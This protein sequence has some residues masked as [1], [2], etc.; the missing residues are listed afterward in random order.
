MTKRLTPEMMMEGK[1]EWWTGDFPCQSILWMVDLAMTDSI[2]KGMVNYSDEGFAKTDQ[3]SW[4]QN[5]SVMG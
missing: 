4:R 5:I 2:P 1:Y 3:Y